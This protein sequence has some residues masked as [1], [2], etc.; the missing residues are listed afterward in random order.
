MFIIADYGLRHGCICSHR[1]LH[2][3]VSGRLLVYRYVWY[4]NV[5]VFFPRKQPSFQQS[6]SLGLVISWQISS[7][8]GSGAFPPTI[9]PMKWEPRTPL[10]EGPGPRSSMGGVGEGRTWEGADM[11]GIPPHPHSFGL[12]SIIIL[13]FINI[14]GILSIEIFLN[15]CTWRHKVFKRFQDFGLPLKAK[16]V[17]LVNS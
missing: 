9:N 7:D 17:K 6:A 10:S 15:D 5:F 2:S 8:Y 3:V 14:S 13:L 4:T 1:R 16:V 12:I 11:T